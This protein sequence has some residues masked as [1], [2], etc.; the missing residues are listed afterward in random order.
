MA[1]QRQAGDKLLN[2]SV[3]SIGLRCIDLGIFQRSYPQAPEPLSTTT[4]YLSNHTDRGIQK[5]S[6]A[7]M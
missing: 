7:H 5:D 4:V 1:R 6:C 2:W 3:C